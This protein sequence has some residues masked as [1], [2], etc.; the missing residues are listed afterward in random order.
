MLVFLGIR[1]FTLRLCLFMT[2]YDN[3]LDVMTALPARVEYQH[4]VCFCNAF[5]WLLRWGEMDSSEVVFVLERS[6]GKVIHEYGFFPE[7]MSV[8]KSN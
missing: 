6:K 8:G 5:A 2:T 4:Y 1:L 7:P 3:E